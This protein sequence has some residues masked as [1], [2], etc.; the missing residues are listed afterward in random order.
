[1]YALPRAFQGKIVSAFAVHDGCLWLALETD[2]RLAAFKLS[3]LT[4][5][6]R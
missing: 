3:A 1:V 5:I 2:R 4:E 6:N